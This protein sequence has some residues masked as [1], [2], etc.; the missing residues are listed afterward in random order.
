M[1]ELW[2]V[3]VS[4]DGGKTWHP[5]TN[6]VD[7]REQDGAKRAEK[8]AEQ[9]RGLYQW[10]AVKFTTQELGQW[11]LSANMS[12]AGGILRPP[13]IGQPSFLRKCMR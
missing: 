2:L 1:N 7:F 5:A 9:A 3:M 12:S 13:L 6:Q 8:Y 11:H 4:T 10:R